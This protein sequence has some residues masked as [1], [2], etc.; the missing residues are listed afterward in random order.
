MGMYFL[1]SPA[2]S[3]NETDAI[4]VDIQQ[5][6]SQPALIEQA[7]QLMS[8]LKQQEP[9]DIMALMHVSEKIAQLNVQRNQVWSWSKEQ[10]FSTQGATPAKAAVYLFDGDVY[11]GL[12]V[13]NMNG[14][15]INYLNQHVGILS[16]LY[17]LLKPLDLILPYRLEMGTK[18]TNTKGSHL[19]DFWGTQIAE[20][21]NQRMQLIQATDTDAA[22]N[23]LVNLASNEYFKAV[24]KKALTGN[25]I[26]PRFEDQ[27]NGKYKVISFYAKKAR[28][29]MV[30]YA[31]DNQLNHAEQLKGFDLAGY[32][33]VEAASDDK[34][35]TFR[36][37]EVV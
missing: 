16:G 5:S 7:C 12:D 27:K 35:W 13:Y 36:R 2:K 9:T 19:Y 6:Y 3:L 17:G 32:Y 4:P 1:L 20:L 21:I 37:D 31:V 23:I 15:A 14:D 30:K 10:P 18:L 22:D 26:T 29:M 8:I 24:Q 25:I 33:Y 11:T 34:T 28:G